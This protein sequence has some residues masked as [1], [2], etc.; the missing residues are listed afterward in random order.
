MASAKGFADAFLLE[1]HHGDH[2]ED[3]GTPSITEYEKLA[4]DFLN[5]PKVSW[6]HECFR[7]AGDLV[8]YD[9]VTNRLAISSPKGVIRTF[10]K[11]RFCKDLPPADRI[12]KC[13]N[14]VSHLEYAKKV[15][16]E[17]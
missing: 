8:R 17:T 11:P 6:F 10:F 13:H 7:K 3:F 15:C 4:Q 12:K 14:E 5:E 9:S 2:A 1:Q 16:R